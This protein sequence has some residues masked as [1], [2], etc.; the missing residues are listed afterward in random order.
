VLYEELIKELHKEIEQMK[1][2]LAYGHASDYSMYKEV[3]GNIAGI[4]RSI[5]IVKDYLTK[6]IE[7][8]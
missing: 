6:Y 8:D 7:E 5:G 1:N 3:V 2:S 4:E